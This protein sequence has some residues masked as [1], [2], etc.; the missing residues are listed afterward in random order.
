M[1]LKE[2]TASEQEL[3]IKRVKETIRDGY[4]FGGVFFMD[5]SPMEEREDPLLY[6]ASMEDIPF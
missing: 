5:S 2:L 4:T 1:E 6:L 3:F